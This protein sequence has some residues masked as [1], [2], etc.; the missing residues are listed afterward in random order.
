MSTDCVDYELRRQIVTVV[1]VRIRSPS[2][3]SYNDIS[4]GYVRLQ[5]KL[6]EV[7]LSHLQNADWRGDR[8]GHWTYEIGYDVDGGPNQE[9][10]ESYSN[11][12]LVC[13]LPIAVYDRAHTGTWE[14]PQVSCLLLR[15]EDVKKMKF[16]RIGWM[17]VLDD[18][19]AEVH[20]ELRWIIEYACSEHQGEELDVV[21]I[22]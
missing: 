9:D 17:S 6:G 21:T 11:R 3:N 22:L 4:N 18:W 13:C 2:G 12:E 19:E 7:N 8:N 20:P 15:T 16:T 1:K 10:I 14:S 5:G